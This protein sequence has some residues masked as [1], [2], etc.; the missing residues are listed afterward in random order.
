MT[1]TNSVVYEKPLGQACFKAVLP[2]LEP[3]KVEEK[4]KTR[5][6]VKHEYGAFFK[7]RYTIFYG[8]DRTT[9]PVCLTKTKLDTYMTRGRIRKVD[10]LCPSCGTAY[11]LIRPSAIPKLRLPL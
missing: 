5:E 2:A 4:P 6:A 3:V 9:C 10:H 1:Q 8:G 7:D 11:P